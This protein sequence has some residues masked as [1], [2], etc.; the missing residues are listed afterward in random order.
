MKLMLKTKITSGKK[1]G[2]VIVFLGGVAIIFGIVSIVLAAAKPSSKIAPASSTEATRSGSTAN[3]ICTTDHPIHQPLASANSPYLQKLAQYEQVCGSGIVE[4]VS[5][6]VSTPTTI[7]EAHEYARGVAIQLREFA[8]Y[9][10]SPVIFFE[11]TTSNGLADMQKYRE[12]G[13]DAALNAYFATLKADGITDVMMG[14][15]VPLPEGN[16]PIWDSVKPDDFVACVTKAISYQKKHFPNSSASILL[17]TDTY[18]TSGSWVGG[19][20][21]SLLP[22]VIGIPDGLIDSFGL[23]GLPWSA[24][25]NKG[26]ATNGT[27]RQYLRTELAAEAARAIG[28]EMIWLNT[29]TFSVKYP[30]EPDQRIAV[31]AAQR[32]EQLLGVI[33]AV[34]SLQSLNF[35]VAVHLFAEDKSTTDEAADWSYWPNGKA[36]TSSSTIVFQTFVRDLRAADVPLWLS[37]TLN[38]AE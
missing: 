24:P 30:N 9:G 35:A 29:G 10:I 3:T 11:P 2:M 21:V 31:T 23:Q 20:A 27:V 28:V 4:K 16:L 26:G 32:Q 5:F 7:V 33:D 17:D 12:G 1:Q 8:A 18:D 6:F 15:W 14:T 34:K 13:Y 36:A 38:E 22:Y 19:Q 37:D 25:A